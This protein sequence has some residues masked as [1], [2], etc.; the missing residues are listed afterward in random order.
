MKT[1]IC[2]KC[3]GTY[4]EWLADAKWNNDSQS[5]VVA[6]IRDCWCKDCRSYVK[7]IKV[8]FDKWI[9]NGQS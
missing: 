6:K 4:L 3:K 5:H 1:Y 8:A 2:P 9:A 7:P